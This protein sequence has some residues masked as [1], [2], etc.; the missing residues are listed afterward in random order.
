M[1]T[2]NRRGYRNTAPSRPTSDVMCIIRRFY[3]DDGQR[4]YV[5][6]FEDCDD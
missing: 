5:L 4:Y 6:T 3:D 1:E 2:R